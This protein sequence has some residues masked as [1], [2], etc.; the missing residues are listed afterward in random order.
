MKL[1]RPFYRIIIPTEQGDFMLR[2]EIG[3][4]GYVVY[5]TGEGCV[6]LY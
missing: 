1:Y 2:Y 5:Y 6:V 4:R 3:G